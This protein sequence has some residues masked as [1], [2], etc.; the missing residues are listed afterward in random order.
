MKWY[1]I[2]AIYKL[3]RKFEANEKPAVLLNLAKSF[4]FYQHKVLTYLKVEF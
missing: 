4:V 3:P 2:R 1:S